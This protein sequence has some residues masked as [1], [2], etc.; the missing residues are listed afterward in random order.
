MND[1]LNEKSIQNTLIPKD[2]NFRKYFLNSQDNEMSM[3]R[4]NIFDSIVSC[5]SLP[6]LD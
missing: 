2:E 5:N 6:P 1:N 4:Q 3:Q